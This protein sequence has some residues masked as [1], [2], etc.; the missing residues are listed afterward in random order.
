MTM[1]AI[2]ADGYVLWSLSS[3]HMYT[4]MVGGFFLSVV[5]ICKYQWY[6]HKCATMLAVNLNVQFNWPKDHDPCTLR[7][8]RIIIYSSWSNKKEGKFHL[9]KEIII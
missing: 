8:S 9:K 1:D 6:N 4:K 5:I 2:E 3:S 7:Y